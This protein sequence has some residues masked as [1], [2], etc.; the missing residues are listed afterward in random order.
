MKK[1]ELSGQRFGRLLVIQMDES[2]KNGYSKWLCLCD[3]GK[4]TVVYGTN[5]RMG[6]SNSCG[7]LRIEN[8]IK[9]STTHGRRHTT[10]YAIWS[11]IKGRCLNKK[12][13]AYP[14]YGGRGITICAEWA[15]SFEFFFY[16]MGER[17]N[18]LLTVERRDNNLGYCKLN[19]YWGTKKDQS[20]NRNYTV[21]LEYNGVRLPK[22]DWAKK[23]SINAGTITYRLNKGQKFVDIVEFFIKTLK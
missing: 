23:L 13:K 15:N 10:E 2:N 7:C 21:W 1:L 9:A 12:D 5:L 18:L 6:G 17:P 19:C 3:C 22:S 14:K 4:T 11:G 20:D 16:E 8:S